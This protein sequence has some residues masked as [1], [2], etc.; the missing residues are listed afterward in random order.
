M[1]TFNA[2]QNLKSFRRRHSFSQGR[3]GRVFMLFLSIF[4]FVSLFGCGEDEQSETIRPIAI[5]VTKPVLRD[6]ENQ[7]AY[8]GTVHS[9]QEVRV[10][11]QVQGTVIS[12]PYQEGDRVNKGELVARIDAPDLQAAVDRLR[13][14]QEYWCRRYEADQRLVAAEALPVEQM[15]STKRACLGA[16]AAL[17]EAESRLAKTVEKSPLNGQVL[18][19]FVEPGQSVMPGQPILL[20]GENQLEIHTE[21]VEEDLRQGIKVGIPAEVNDG[22]GNRFRTKI[23]EVSPISSGRSRTFTVRLAAPN[24]EGLNLPKGSSVRVVFILKESNEAI[25]VPLNAVADRDKNPHIFVIRDQQAFHQ[26]VQLDIE[27]DGWIE[28]AF[29]WNGEDLVAV[30]N[31]GSLKDSIPVFTVAVEEVQ[32]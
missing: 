3:F 17:A 32:Q 11:A 7:L 20:L 9:K 4:I 21:V 22:L 14:E 30:S 6:M 16:K 29:P 26:P 1:T 15:E 10:I 19:R 2:P 24:P 13:A 28:A 31:L 23:I 12:L 18:N 5:R 25:T 27:K 8:L